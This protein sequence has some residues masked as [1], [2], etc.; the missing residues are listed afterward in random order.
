MNFRCI[1]QPRPCPDFWQRI[2]AVTAESANPGSWKSES[3]SSSFKPRSQRK[4]SSPA[5]LASAAAARR[6]GRQFRSLRK[7]RAARAR[8]FANSRL[9]P[10]HQ[11]R[12]AFPRARGGAP[13]SISA[14]ATSAASLRPFFS[15]ARRR[16]TRESLRLSRPAEHRVFNAP[17]PTVQGG[18]PLLE[19]R[20]RV[21]VRLL[22][23]VCGCGESRGLHGRGSKTRRMSL[24]VLDVGFFVETRL[25]S[26]AGY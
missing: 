15:L 11:L 13:G 3:L 21:C 26:D 23:C 2:E 24:Q 12:A 22:E 18:E 17:P 5:S 8:I 7:S 25:S 1:T 19:R 9:P 10:R 14:S 16:V 20:I 6:D 4:H